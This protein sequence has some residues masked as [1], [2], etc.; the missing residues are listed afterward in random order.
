MCYIFCA[1]TCRL[2]YP[3]C[4]AHA[5]V[6]Y[7]HLWPAPLYS[8]FPHYLI[9]GTIFLKKKKIIEHKICVLIFSIILSEK[10]IIL[11]STVRDNI[12]ICWSWCKIPVILF[13][14][15]RNF[16]FLDTISK[17]N[18]YQISWKSVQ[19]EPSYSVWTDGR[20]DMTKLT[21]ALRNFV[22]EPKNGWLC[23]GMSSQP[24]YS[25]L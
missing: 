6:L 25:V 9:N 3:A 15:W 8:I 13:R 4:N 2:R 7:C 11:I 17:R 23:S 18:Q 5:A 22:N 19:W 1:C 16:N 24:S 12:S 14:F 20:T 10:F 21:V